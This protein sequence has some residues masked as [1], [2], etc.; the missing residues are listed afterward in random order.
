MIVLALQTK[1]TSK[2]FHTSRN[3]IHGKTEVPFNGIPAIMQGTTPRPFV[4]M[5][6]RDPYHRLY[7][8][9]IDK[10][11]LLGL[12][13]RSITKAL[14][15]K[16]NRINDGYCGYNIT[17][18]DYLDYVVGQAFSGA[19]MN[20]HYAPVSELCDVCHTQYDIVCSQET[21]MTDTK[22]LLN[23]LRIDSSKRKSIL[24]DLNKNGI[25]DLIYSLVKS[26]AGDYKTYYP[27]CPNPVLL[28]A[29]TW[30]TLKYQG[31]ILSTTPF[32]EETFKS[33]KYHTEEA[34]NI[35]TIIMDVMATEN[36]TPAMR[37][38]Q[39]RKAMA[40]AYQEIKQYTLLSIQEVYH[41]DFE[42]FGYSKEPPQL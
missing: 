3:A 13:G 6:S 41:R 35:T 38:E 10:Y 31:Y 17:F 32:P 23:K 26:Y 15:R 34:E 28:F 1:E 42:L 12:L 7:S 18:Q 25:R 33:F 20:E 11:Y 24:N 22:F 29:R 36:M 40:Q 30:N 2:M 16:L 21:L 9:F 27:D 5:A 14:N 19:L 39:R 8:V 37:V 4:I